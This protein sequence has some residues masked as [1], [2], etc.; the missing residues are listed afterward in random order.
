MNVWPFVNFE[1]P[2]SPAKRVAGI[3]PGADCLL[4]DRRAR[5][6]D[7]QGTT[8]LLS[9]MTL[10]HLSIPAIRSRYPWFQVTR[11]PMDMRYAPMPPIPVQ[12]HRFDRS[13]VDGAIA[14]GAG[15]R[16]DA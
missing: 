12:D 10:M 15:D 11:R 1:G 3:G 8:Q 13:H 14:I 5:K 16:L 9:L 7:Y 2:V 6:A 4:S